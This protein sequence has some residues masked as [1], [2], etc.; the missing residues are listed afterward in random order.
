MAADEVTHYLLS[1]LRRRQVRLVHGR[2]YV[3]DLPGAH[4]DPLRGE[5]IL[6]WLRRE[7][8]LRRRQVLAARPLTL[9][10]LRRVHDDSYLERL[11]DPRSLVP[12]LGF[13]VDPDLGVS[14]LAA[15]RAQCGGTLAAAR[16]AL[17]HGGVAVNL[18]GGFHH[19]RRDR[20]AGF[21]AF[22]D[23]AAAVADLRGAGFTER[24]LVVDL[25]LHDG[26]GTRALFADDPSVHTLSIH[27]R[28][29]DTAPAIESTSVELGDGVEDGAYLA[30]LD[31]IL[32]PLLARFSPALV[33][34]LAGADVAAG[35][36]LGNWRLTPRGVLAR[37]QRVVILARRSTPPLACVWL[38]AGGYGAEAW[39]HSARSLAWLLSGR[40]LE[41]AATAEIAIHRY[42]EL[43][44]AISPAELAGAEGDD[45]GLTLAD[46][47]LGAAASRGRLLGQMTAHGLELALERL[48]ILDRLRALGFAHPTLELDLG[49]PGG[50]TARLYG[51]VDRRELLIELRVRL[52]RGTIPEMELLRVE[53]LLLQNPRARFSEARPGLPGQTHPGLGLAEDVAALLVL[54][55]E[56]LRLDGVL[57]VPS[58]YHL[59][60]QAGELLRFLDS[61]DEARW[62]A[63]RQALAGKPLAE[64][65]A[66]VAGGR[67][68][69]RRTGEPVR[70]GATPMVIPVSERLAAR[71]TGADYERRVEEA[72]RGLEFDLVN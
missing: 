58:H 11:R 2:R 1:T 20:G 7:R 10:A 68:V 57:F 62:R 40:E 59:V 23:V 51:D 33:V 22:N 70:W 63:L 36:R 19:A 27:S 24:V 47:G 61:R 4:T 3:L 52:D 45:W 6:V 65:T 8:L 46:L 69:D 53:W 32:P 30:A 17:A 35:D 64:A 16:W 15:S 5:R 60:G 71:I 21:C 37:D 14:F 31:E 42:R 34:Y 72:A 39:R 48:G 26:D 38:L 56:R 29:W 25:D 9:K 28:S 44:R 67:V 66:A 12:I 55:C 41:P 43:G 50:E 13:E 49:H 54:T 18:G